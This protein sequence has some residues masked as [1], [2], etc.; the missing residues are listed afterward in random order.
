MCPWATS[1]WKMRSHIRYP[2]CAR[3]LICSEENGTT[4]C[5]GVPIHGTMKW[6]S[7]FLERCCSRYSRSASRR[8]WLTES[9]SL[10][11][12]RRL[13]SPAACWTLPSSWWTTFHFSLF[14]WEWKIQGDYLVRISISIDL[15]THA[16]RDDSGTGSTY[17]RVV[18]KNGHPMLVLEVQTVSFW[19]LF[20]QYGLSHRERGQQWAFWR[21]GLIWCDS[22]IKSDFWAVSVAHWC[23]H[24]AGCSWLSCTVTHTQI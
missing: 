9:S 8:Y 20:E 21:W 14:C 15:S 12:S 13:S 22:T 18:N 4:F 11:W 19:T 3:C 10:W 7:L 2:R 24:C 1:C 23:C 5:I 6:I 16:L 17:F